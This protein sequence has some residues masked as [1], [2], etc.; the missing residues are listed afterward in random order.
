[1]LSARKQSTHPFPNCCR[2]FSAQLL[3]SN[4]LSQRV[5]RIDRW[6]N[7]DFVA[8]GARDEFGKARISASE[9]TV[10]FV[11]VHTEMLI[12]HGTTIAE[13]DEIQTTNAENG[14][15]PRM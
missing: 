9:M 12:I 10:R 2:G 7:F 4:R 6:K 1:M 3:V 13:I 15:Q 11:V 8:T 5:K 14:D